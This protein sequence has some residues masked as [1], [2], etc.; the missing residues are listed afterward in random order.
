MADSP[1]KT[2][3]EDELLASVSRLEA[4]LQEIE[5][6]RKQQALI[7]RVGVI[8]ILVAILLFAWNIWNF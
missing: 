1:K 5:K 2:N 4:D 3:G 7:I 8:L 6:A